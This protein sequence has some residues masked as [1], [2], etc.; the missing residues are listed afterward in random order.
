MREA[1][2]ADVGTTLMA[3]LCLPIIVAALFIFVDK[4]WGKR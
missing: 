1:T 4:M 3:V 2:M